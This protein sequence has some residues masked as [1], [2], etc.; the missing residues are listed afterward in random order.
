MTDDFLSSPKQHEL[1]DLVPNFAKCPCEATSKLLDQNDSVVSSASPLIENFTTT[2]ATQVNL[3]A[4]AV[5]E[6]TAVVQELAQSVLKLNGSVVSPDGHPVNRQGTKDKV[7]KEEATV[8]GH[9]MLVPRLSIVDGSTTNGAL[10]LSESHIE[11]LVTTETS[12]LPQKPRELADL[13]VFDEPELL[14]SPAQFTPKRR[15]LE[16]SLPLPQFRF[17]IAAAI[18]FTVSILCFCVS[19][20][21]DFVY[22]DKR[23]ILKNKDLLPDTPLSE[24][25]QND[26]WGKKLTNE[27]SHKS[28]RP[29]TI[30]TF[31]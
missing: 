24:L 27:T 19:Y 7:T 6:E 17:S 30:L 5:K 26:F 28:Y 25:F 15:N 13:T 22:D 9:L 18:V 10:P 31:R 4:P 23:A 8:E 2:V 16:T 29:L 20:D 21:G 14:E 3:D 1:E 12:P 11:D